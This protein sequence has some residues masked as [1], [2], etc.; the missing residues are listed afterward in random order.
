MIF[1]TYALPLLPNTYTYMLAQT[2]VTGVLV[3]C[4]VRSAMYSGIFYTK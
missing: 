3:L 2:E 4:D 1:T